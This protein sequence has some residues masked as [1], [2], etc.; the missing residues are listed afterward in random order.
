MEKNANLRI[1]RYCFLCRLTFIGHDFLIREIQPTNL[2]RPFIFLP[3]IAISSRKVEIFL[4]SRV[5]LNPHIVPVSPVR[6][7]L[8][9]L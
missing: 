1:S 2:A 4:P 9:T 5:S 3:Q 7:K 6:A 8:A